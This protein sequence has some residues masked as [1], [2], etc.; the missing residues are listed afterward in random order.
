MP[1]KQKILL[2]LLNKVVKDENYEKACVI[3]D[4]IKRMEDGI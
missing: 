2:K 1:L 3:R 4:E